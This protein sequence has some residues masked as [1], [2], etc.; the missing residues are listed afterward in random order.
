MSAPHSP[1]AER[2]LLSCFLGSPSALA[3]VSEL[4]PDDFYLSLHRQVFEAILD[5]SNEQRP[6]DLVTVAGCLGNPA[7]EA[8]LLDIA[9]AAPYWHNFRAYAGQVMRDGT[10][11][12]LIAACTEI[13]SRAHVHDPGEVLSEARR[14]LADL[15]GRTEGGPVRLGER[16]SDVLETIGARGQGKATPAISSGIA[17]YDRLIGPFKPGQL[18]VV[19]ARPGIGKTAFAGSC[20]LRAAKAGVP[21]LVFSLEM[22]FQEMAERF[23]GAN[24]RVSVEDI[25]RAIRKHTTEPLFLGQPVARGVAAVGG[26]PRAEPGADGVRG[27]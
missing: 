8:G 25:G 17:S 24:A 11:R 23:L 6:V 16:M 15:E 18:V 19:A 27:S 1:D 21:A 13:A 7:L 14:T 12:R 4:R 10:A 5:L 26:R 2:S 3:I 20:A 22:Q 9:T